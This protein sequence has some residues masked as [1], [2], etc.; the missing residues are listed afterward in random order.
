MFYETIIKYGSWANQIIFRNKFQLIKIATTCACWI[1]ANVSIVAAKAP[2][3]FLVKK[4]PPN[5]AQNDEEL[6]EQHYE[7][8]GEEQLSLVTKIFLPNNQSLLVES[9][10][11][12]CVQRFFL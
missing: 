4:G 7:Q 6:K 10:N 11:F 5:S 2:K 1:T 9:T 8:G 3:K 12:K